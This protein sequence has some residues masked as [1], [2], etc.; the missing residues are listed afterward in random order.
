MYPFIIS[1]I[2]VFG[3][4][5]RTLLPYCP[6]CEKHIAEKGHL[7]N[8]PSAGEVIEKGINVAEMDAKLL[9]KIE[10]LILYSI[11]QNKR[12]QS[13]SEEINEL[14]RQVQLLIS[15]HK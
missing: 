2:G 10:E 6:V 11:D 3:R 7:P 8:I 4:S 13:Q 14:K 15:N 12:L 5:V 1:L 9:E